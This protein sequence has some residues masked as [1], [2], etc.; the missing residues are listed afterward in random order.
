MV[1]C[2]DSGESGVGNSVLQEAQVSLGKAI[3]GRQ[4]QKCN[5]QGN[6]TFPGLCRL[7]RNQ[8][9]FLGGT[10][11]LKMSFAMIL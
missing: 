11:K 6:C 4:R 2:D 10:V 7:P 9:G 5:Y 1:A 3:T 8:D